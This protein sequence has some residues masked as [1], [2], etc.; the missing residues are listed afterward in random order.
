MAKPKAANWPTL[1]AYWDEYGHSISWDQLTDMKVRDDGMYVVLAWKDP[2]GDIGIAD[3]A[4]GGGQWDM[5]N[6]GFPPLT[7][8][9]W[10]KLR[11]TPYCDS[12]DI[13]GKDWRNW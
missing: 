8:A 7:P 6:D 1:K 3:V 11:I 5:Q 4:C 12:F 2:D 13:P 10:R 9:E